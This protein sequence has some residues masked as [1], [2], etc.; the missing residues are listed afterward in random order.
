MRV[1]V[2]RPNPIT[3]VMSIGETME[4]RAV[5]DELSVEGTWSWST[6]SGAIRWTWKEDLAGGIHPGME[7]YASTYSIDSDTNSVVT[8]LKPS[9]PDDWNGWRNKKPITGGT[10]STGSAGNGAI[11]EA[12]VVALEK[13][14]SQHPK[15]TFD[16]KTI[17]IN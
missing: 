6:V 10:S 3:R 15:A 2:R 7:E 14:D 9:E 4:P 1:V 17:T 16:P 8:N 12:L 13:L 5:G 11:A